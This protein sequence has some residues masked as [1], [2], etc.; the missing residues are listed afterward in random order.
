MLAKLVTLVIKKYI[1]H[2]YRQYRGVWQH[3]TVHALFNSTPN[4]FAG[5]WVAAIAEEADA[6][7]KVAPG[8]AEQARVYKHPA[9][10]KK[11]LPRPQLL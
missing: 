6:A 9:L 4:S 7:S 8:T 3:L 2:Q 1:W 10:R 11:I 5:P